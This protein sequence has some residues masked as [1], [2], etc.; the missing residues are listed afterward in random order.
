MLSSLMSWLEQVHLG[1]TN[2]WLKA[3]STDLIAQAAG[4]I[5]VC[6]MG[7]RALSTVY[8]EFWRP[9]S[10]WRASTQQAVAEQREQQSHERFKPRLKTPE[11][12]VS[13]PTRCCGNA[14]EAQNHACRNVPSRPRQQRQHVETLVCNLVVDPVAAF[15]MSRTRN[16]SRAPCQR[17]SLVSSRLPRIR[18]G[19]IGL[20]SAVA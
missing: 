13:C 12:G 4:H 17:R 15:R 19:V 16:V 9:S 11:S 20:S 14:H 6:R 5:G 18:R 3:S 8:T 2:C 1:S 10:R 7:S